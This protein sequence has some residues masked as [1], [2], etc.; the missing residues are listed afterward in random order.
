VPFG[1]P[2]FL[3]LTGRTVVVIGDGAVR[4]GK[5]RGLLAAGAD[6]VVV[7]APEAG[8]HPD[9]PGDDGGVTIHPRPWEPRD[10]DGAFLCIASSADPGERD[11]IARAARHR[12]VLVNVMDDVANCDF[13][14]PAVV[15]RGDLAIAISTGGRSPAAARRLREMLGDRFGP[16]WE[17][18]IEILRAVREDTLPMLPDIAERSR[19][20][21]AALDLDEAQGLVSGGR[22]DELRARLR[23]RLIEDGVA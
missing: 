5:V 18:L 7:I 17:E 15:R 2:A 20:W 9:L 11:E 23:R 1:F 10:L 13:A 16:E 22:G 8:D 21:R 14:A 6:R 12:R 3:E 4:D 19:R